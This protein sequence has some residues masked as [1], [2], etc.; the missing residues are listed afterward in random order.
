LFDDPVLRRQ[1]NKK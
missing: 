1:S